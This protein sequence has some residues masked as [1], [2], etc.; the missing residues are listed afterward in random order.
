MSDAPEVF[1]PADFVRRGPPISVKELDRQQS[2]KWAR[3]V[4]VL[5]EPREQDGLTRHAFVTKGPFTL[6]LA[7][8]RAG[9]QLGSKDAWQ[10]YTHPY[11][12]FPADAA[13]YNVPGK[14]TLGARLQ[15]RG[16]TG[17]RLYDE[18]GA[19]LPDA[20]FVTESYSA[21]LGV[22]RHRALGGKEPLAQPWARDLLDLDL[23]LLELF[24]LASTLVRTDRPRRTTIAI[25]ALLQAPHL[26][27]FVQEAFD[28]EDRDAIDAIA[29]GASTDEIQAMA[30]GARFRVDEND[31]TRITDVKDVKGRQ[32]ITE[33]VKEHAA[34][35]EQHG[36]KI[37]E[38]SD[39]IAAAEAQL[40]EIKKKVLALQKDEAAKSRITKMFSRNPQTIT[41]LKAA[42]VHAIRTKRA[43]EQSFSEIPGYDRLR[44]LSDRVKGFQG[45][46]H[47][48]FAL[49]GRFV[50]LNVTEAQL[51]SMRDL[52]A[53]KV[54]DQPLEAARGALKQYDFRLRADVL[55]RVLN[56]YSL[57]AYVLR[58][59]D[60][61]ARGHSL[62]SVQR[63][64][65]LARH[66]VEYFR[67]ARYGE[68]TLG[69]AFDETWGQVIQLEARL[70]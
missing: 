24:R 33:L 2:E 61:L 48:V 10:F 69:N 53:T 21:A 44:G 55:P 20:E 22:L 36:D 11:K 16:A 63:L 15:V 40:D 45:S 25:H 19:G 51:K 35:E 23:D 43:L 52:V 46:I 42:G 49:T 29:T 56:A 50:E 64:N 59:P 31:F 39:G 30:V 8:R 26:E 9:T 7:V 17:V 32:V 34:F 27:R 28:Q 14:G 54:A 4:L 1:P 70:P 66:L 58:R 68:K 65:R 47:A 13:Y 5:P 60:A 3:V 62:K 41:D 38:I 67:W 18:V 37:R 6:P 12:V 57:S